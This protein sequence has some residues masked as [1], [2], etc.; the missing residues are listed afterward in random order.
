MTFEGVELG[1]KLRRTPHT[2]RRPHVGAGQDSAGDRADRRRH[3]DAGGVRVGEE[4]HPRGRRDRRQHLVE[5]EAE[6]GVRHHL[7]EL[8]AGDRRVEAED[9]ERRLGDDRL[10]HRSANLSPQI[11]DRDRHDPFVEAVDE[12][13]A[14]R[15]DAEI[16]RHGGGCLGVRRVEPEL[17]GAQP[18]QRLDDAR[19][20]AAGVLVLVQPQ[21]VVQLRRFLV[22]V[23][24]DGWLIV[25]SASPRSI[26]HAPRGL[27]RGRAPGWPARSATTRRA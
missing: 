6:V 12:G 13:D 18:G 16:L 8:A 7:H 1:T 21:A 4:H 22:V 15:V 11:G 2:L 9:L 25:A 10:E 19:R 27:R 23:L 14:V 20:T 24:H 5:R 3:A 26:R 17:L